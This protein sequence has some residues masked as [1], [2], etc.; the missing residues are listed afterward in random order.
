M[1]NTEVSKYTGDA[2]QVKTIEDAQ[3][4]ITDVWFSDYE[5][6][7]Y[8]RLALIEK[9]SQELIGFC[10]LK[11]L[12]EFK[13]PDLGYRMLPQY[14]GKG[15]AT[16]S[17]RAALDYGVNSLDMKTIMGL[18]F[19]ENTSS[20]KVLKKLGFIKKEIIEVDGHKCN[21]FLYEPDQ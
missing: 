17:A 11:Y 5:K 20:Q 2:G 6:Y 9:E 7:G 15:Y 19:P 3:R 1:A 10:G 16:E 4:V 8:G 14:W 21:L 18:T 12:P 13:K